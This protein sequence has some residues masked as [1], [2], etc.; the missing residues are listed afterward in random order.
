L[1]FMKLTPHIHRSTE[2]KYGWSFASVP[3][4]AFVVCSF[5]IYSSFLSNF[6]TKIGTCLSV[7]ETGANARIFLDGVF[8]IIVGR[9]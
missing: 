9:V 1:C 2:D 6:N 4:Y 5:V 8:E 3:P 7:S